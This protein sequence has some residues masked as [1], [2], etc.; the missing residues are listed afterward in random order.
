MPRLIGRRALIAAATLLAARPALAQRVTQA[1]AAGYDTVVAHFYADPKPEKLAGFLDRMAGSPLPWTAFPP[2]VGFYAVLFHLHPDWIP[3]L[4]PEKF[5]ARTSA[6]VAAAWRLGQQPP[7]AQSLRA[8]IDAAGHDLPLDNA[9]T[10]LPEKLADLHV[11]T[12][13]HLDIL[14]GAFYASGDPAYPQQ[15]LDFFAQL[16]DRADTMA[17]DITNVTIAMAG[18]PKDVYPAIRAKYPE[19]VLRGIVFAATAE[20]ALLSNAREHPAVETLVSDYI[21][22]HQKSGSGRSLMAIRELAHH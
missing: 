22:H 2:L 4:L 6:T 17:N 12:P 20:W 1:P 5:D 21:A 3:Q 14:W 10:D 8:R 11:T 13:T 15:I 16:A 19:N 18:G 7:M 9:L